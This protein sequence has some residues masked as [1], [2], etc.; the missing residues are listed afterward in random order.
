MKKYLVTLIAVMFLVTSLGVASAQDDTEESAFI[1]TH[2]AAALTVEEGEDD[3][4]VL[5][6]YENF[7]RGVQVTPELE[8]GSLSPEGWM[9]I[10]EARTDLVVSDAVLVADD[11]AVK[12]TL[13][14]PQYDAAEDALAYSATIESMTY[15]GEPITLA[16]VEEDIFYAPILFIAPDEDFLATVQL[17][18]G[19]DTRGVF[20]PP[21]CFWTWSC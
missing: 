13:T 10:W 9:E 18:T 12:L 11:Y 21:W 7:I 4:F 15:Q 5:I 14:K 1:I 19:S 2:Y 20:I 3:T 17:I 6:F 16:D 8:G